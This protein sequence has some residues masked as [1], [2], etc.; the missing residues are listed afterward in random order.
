MA[1]KSETAVREGQYV[2]RMLKDGGG[3]AR[4]VMVHLGE[5]PLV[6]LRSRKLLT[7]RQFLA[8]EA[9]RRDWE[10]AGLGPRVTMRWDLSPP[11][12]G[13]RGAPSAPDPTITQLSA[14]E[15]FHAALDKA[16][17][18]LSD[19]LW[20]VVCAGEGIG[21]AEKALQWPSRAGKLVLTL[22]LDRVAAFY[23]IR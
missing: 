11:S 19:I 6:W 22:A 16:G 3:I 12:G 8:G 15:R 21:H 10:L 7:N 2:E 5:S 14:R 13:R 18:G 17:P 20:R 23:R 4:K 9:L 1:S